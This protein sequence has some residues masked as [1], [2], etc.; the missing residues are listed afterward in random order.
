M[1][2]ARKTPEAEVSPAYQPT[3]GPGYY[4]L[5]P[6]LVRADV[7]VVKATNGTNDADTDNDDV[8]ENGVKIG[9]RK[10]IFILSTSG[11]HQDEMQRPSGQGNRPQQ[12]YGYFLQ[13]N[14][15]NGYFF[16][17][18]PATGLYG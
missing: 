17:R 7:G 1:V 13:Q 10:P 4:Y 11:L 16:A 5:I 15:S 18:P 8:D 3:P 12:T 14:P 6:V 9:N 2:L